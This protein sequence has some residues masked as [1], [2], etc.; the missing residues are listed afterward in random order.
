V[1]ACTRIVPSRHHFLSPGTSVSVASTR[2]SRPRGIVLE[3]NEGTAYG[4]AAVSTAQAI[5]DE[6]QNETPQ[7]ARTVEQPP[8]SRYDELSDSITVARVTAVW[9]RSP[10]T[11][12]R[13]R[14]GSSAWS[15]PLLSRASVPPFLFHPT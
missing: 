14:Q 8:H 12:A 9:S 1:T 7:P 3:G 13:R 5:G 2:M 4:A 10:A 11:V 6:T 15:R